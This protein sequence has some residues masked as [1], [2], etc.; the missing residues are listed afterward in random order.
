MGAEHA[1]LRSEAV[2]EALVQRLRLLGPGGGDVGGPVALAGVAVERE[3]GDDQ[4]LAL[5]Q[6][7]VH[8]PVAVGEDPEGAHL[9]GQLVGVGLRVVVRDAE[10]HEQAGADLGHA[11]AVRIHRRPAHPLHQRSHGR[12]TMTDATSRI[13]TVIIV[14]HTISPAANG[15]S[16]P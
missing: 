16:S 2:G 7:L 10:Q 3:L 13:G 6:R 11:L 14:V 12:H 9:V 1:A 15:T 8:P 5:A 4:D